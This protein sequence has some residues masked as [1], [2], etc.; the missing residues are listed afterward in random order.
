VRLP[1]W[2]GDAVM[3]T[4]ALRAVRKARPGSRILAVGRRSVCA[5]LDG[6]SAVDGFLEAP[7]RGLG[8][9][10]ASARELR[11][12]GAGEALVLPHSFS[13]A[14]HVWLARIPRRIGYRTRER[15]P[16][17]R[18][19]WPERHRG[20]RVP[21]PMTRHYLRL[22]RELGAGAESEHLDLAVTAAEEAEAGRRLRALGVAEDEPYVAINP[23]ASFGASK[24]WTVEGFAA[25]VRG[26][27][28]LRGWRGLVLCGP[29]EEELARTIAQEAG[30]AAVDTSA[31]VLP[32]P[33]LKP[34]LRDARLLVT[35][36]T[37]PRHIATAFRR[38]VVVVMG[39]T[40]P[41]YTAS[42]L[43]RTRVLRRDVDC[44]PCHL[45]TCPIDHRCMTGIG[46]AE[47]VAAAAELLG[48]GAV[49]P[50]EASHA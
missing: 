17:L 25:T 30:A 15:F 9:L 19:P 11:G 33:L 36:D 35:T 22:A 43:E 8:A 31:A 28:E 29:G 48:A 39:P 7:G 47:V 41:R 4:P 18:G 21:E 40:D 13:S 12:L 1:N 14:L 5:L 32:L 20:R 42:N 50:E 37:G 34:V 16:L 6:S 49:D 45:K 3:A 38:P 24:F 46:A 27:W 26:L 23:G 44:G 10:L 2:V